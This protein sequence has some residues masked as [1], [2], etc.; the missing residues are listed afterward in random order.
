MAEPPPPAK[1]QDLGLRALSAFILIPAVIADVWAGGAWFAVCVALVGVLMA[2]EWSDLVHGGDPAQFAIHAAAGL[3]GAI[4]PGGPLVSLVLIAAL[5]L[6][7]V[8]LRPR[9]GAWSYLGVAYVGL[10]AMAFFLLRADA[11][12]GAA[13][14]L[15]VLIAV[16]VADTLAFFAGRIVG[17]PKLWPAVSPKK[18]W[19][20]LGGAVVGGALAAVAFASAAGYGGLLPL[21]LTGAAIGLVEQGG[22]LLESALKRHYGVKDSGRLIPGH[23]GILDR[24]DGLVAAAM[25]AGIIGIS[26]GGTEATGQ[27]L[28]VW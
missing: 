1:W 7:G 26:R 3:V 28:L 22:D 13:A 4:G 16:W 23:G 21:A 19:A 27:G 11:A 12:H 2:R 24:V 5:A 25:F 15:F 8:A 20:G 9:G 10:P 17:G 14:I 18:T 6:A